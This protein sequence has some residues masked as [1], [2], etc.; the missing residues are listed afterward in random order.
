MDLDVFGVFQSVAVIII[1]DAE[2][3]PTLVSGRSFRLTYEAFFVLSFIYLKLFH[4]HYKQF[5][6][7]IMNLI[8]K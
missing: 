3:V 4:H 5:L 7:K 1:T 6:L 8:S 2:L